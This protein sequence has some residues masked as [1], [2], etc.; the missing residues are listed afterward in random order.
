[1]KLSLE[2]S[3]RNDNSPEVP[4]KDISPIL[5]KKQDTTIRGIGNYR[6]YPYFNC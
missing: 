1:M 4:V 5:E 3:D 2:Y 6:Y